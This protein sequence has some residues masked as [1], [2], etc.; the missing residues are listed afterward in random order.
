MKKLVKIK[1]KAQITPK[2]EKIIRASSWF[3]TGVSGVDSLLVVGIPRGTS[4]LVAGGAGSG[5]TI[6]C[7][8]TMMTA[9]QRGEKCLYL[10]FEES[11]LRLRKHMDD[12]NW[13]WQTYE[14]KGSLRIVRKSPLTLLNNIEA[15]V[16]EAK[17]ELLIDINSLIEI[18]PKGFAPDFVVIDSITVISEI[19]VQHEIGYR[20][21]LE[22]LIRYLEK[23]NA[24]SFITSETELIPKIFSKSGIDEFL[25][26]GVIV[27]Y[28]ISEH[29]TR[30]NAIEILKM[31]GAKH[32][33]G[34]V[35]FEIL[36]NGITVYPDQEMF[37][38]FNQMNKTSH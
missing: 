16:T 11:E 34:M 24:T 30:E 17:G 19:F 36:S 3:Q 2:K 27:L 18:I 22:Q 38:S 37:S 32:K 15:L 9:L 20:I 14:K 7:L 25:V 8:Q 6:F 4:V 21:F 23:T 13:D 29:N 31:R 5:K 1:A 35:P 33:K 10:S 28:S 12:F 26:D